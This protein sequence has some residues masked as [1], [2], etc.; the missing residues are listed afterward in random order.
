MTLEQKVDQSRALIAA[1]LQEASDPIV[2]SSFGKDSLVLLDLVYQL[3]RVPVLSFIQGQDIFPEKY[4]FASKVIEENGLDCYTL[5]PQWSTHVQ[6]GSYFELFKCFGSKET[7]PLLMATGC[8]PRLPGEETYLCALEEV[9]EQAREPV[10]YPWD[11][12]FIGA[13]SSDEVKL[14]QRSSITTPVIQSGQT[15]LCFPLWDWTDDDIWTYIRAEGIDYDHA[16][17]DD[18][19]ERTNPDQFPTCWNCLDTRKAGRPVYCPAMEREIQNRAQSKAWHLTNKRMI[20]ETAQYL[21]FDATMPDPEPWTPMLPLREEWPL[22]SVEKYIAHGQVY[23]QIAD[24][25]PLYLAHDGVAHLRREW[26][27]MERACLKAGMVGWLCA[28]EQEN[29]A[30]QRWLEQTGATRYATDGTLQWYRKLVKSDTAYPSL[31]QMVVG[32]QKETVV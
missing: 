27:R 3:L 14:A 29:V 18:R 7:G 6:D 1:Q 32:M 15:R 31:R 21:D 16:R 22:F 19:Q 28:V 20:L 17:Y 9:H 26:I 10:H 11:L 8:R 4:A 30:F 24:L 12:T 2:L 5:P 13:K 25:P 23:L